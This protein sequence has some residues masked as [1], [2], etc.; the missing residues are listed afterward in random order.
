MQRKKI[1]KNPVNSKITTIKLLEET[2]IRLEKLRE[3]K[4]E[5]YDDILRKMLYVL[6]TAREEPEKARKILEKID[7]LRKRMF[8]EK[9]KLQEDL[10]KENNRK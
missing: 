2:K 6:N 1:R 3:H 4:R 9:A 10:A 5:S 8:E 7:E